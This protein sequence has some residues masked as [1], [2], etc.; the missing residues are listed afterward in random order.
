MKQKIFILAPFFFV[1]CLSFFAI[2]PLFIDGFFPMHDDTQVARVYGMGKALADGVFPVRWISDLGYGYGYPIFNYYAPLAYYVGGLATFF[3]DALIATKIMFVT[4]ILLAGITM[5]LFA[6]S[7]WGRIGGVVCA[8]LFL[9]APYHAVQIYVRGDVSEFFA[10]A[11][12]PLV[13]YAIWQT[14]LTQKNIFFVLGIIGYAGLIL[15]HNLTAMMVT[16]FLLMYVLVIFI[17]EKKKIK[18]FLPSLVILGGMGLSAWYWMPALLEIPYTNVLSQIGG[19]ADFR[20]HYVCLGQLWDSQWGFGGSIKGCIDGMAYRIG[21]IPLILSS[22][23]AVI[24]LFIYRREK[25]KFGV[26]VFS[27][28]SLIICILL[29][30][31]ISRSVWETIPLMSFFQ[32]PWR[33]LILI[34][35]FSSF[36]VGVLF[37]YLSKVF[38]MAVLSAAIVAIGFI[39]FFQIK[40]F[41]PQT[42]LARNAEFYT[43]IRALRWATSKISDEY[44]PK[45]FSKPKNESEI[46]LEK[47]DSKTLNGQIIEQDEKT[48][49]LRY[50][51]NTNTPSQI[52]VNIAYFPAWK[53]FLNGKE[54]R[55][56]ATRNGISIL[57]P[58]GK[59]DLI[60]KFQQ[61]PLEK[62]ANMISLT[63][64]GA[65][66]LGIILRRKLIY[67]YEKKHR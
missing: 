44:L 51:I 10:Y 30:L 57:L 6:Q 4:G 65:V 14:Y 28:I 58:Q 13:F 21:K 42:I 39:L 22:I 52:H 55:Y 27:I 11:F 46:V 36:L 61:T 35:F 37:W 7:F 17:M 26:F 47:I 12:V 24:G 32:Y 41:V 38:N 64:I 5:Y 1:V 50:R 53:A 34:S 60:F 56:K 62:I 15:S 23:A 18:L 54:A 2:K 9:Y 3:T 66:V 29:T 49:E 63:S 25:S 48:Q 67:A 31:T 20:D 59:N 33:F 40:L 16:P 8:I 19:G 43:N 45:H